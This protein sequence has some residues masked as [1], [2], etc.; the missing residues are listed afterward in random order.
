MAVDA[1][2]PVETKTVS[3][4]YTEWGEYHY[5]A[6]F[7]VSFGYR[8]KATTDASLQLKRIWFDGELIYDADKGNPKVGVKLYFKPGTS[9]QMPF[10]NQDI[11]YRDQ[12]LL[13]FSNVDLGT[14]G[15]IPAVTAEFWDG[16]T[17][18]VAEAIT[19]LSERAG[20]DAS[21]VL[22]ADYL[23]EIELLGYILD[24]QASL[25]TT[26]SDLAFLYNFTY[27]EARGQINVNFAY[28]TVG[29]F[30]PDV[31]IADGEL[32]VLSEA[33][34][35]PQIDVIAVA[36]D[37]A[38]PRSITGS[39]FDFDKSYERG[40]ETAFRRKDA[41]GSENDMSFSMPVVMTGR[42][43][44]SRLFDALARE[45]NER[46]AHSLRLPTANVAVEPGTTLQW[47]SYGN[48]YSG[49][50]VTAV[51]NADWSNTLSVVEILAE[52]EGNDVDTTSPPL[53]DEYVSPNPVRTVLMDVPDWD[54]NQTKAGLLN[55]RVAMARGSD[56]DTWLGGQFDWTPANSN[57]WTTPAI[58]G[59]DGEVGIGD[60]ISDDGPTMTFYYNSIDP[61]RFDD[62]DKLL[63]VGRPGNWEL[64]TFTDAAIASDGRVMISGLSR[65]LYGTD[66]F[67]NRHRGELIDGLPND[68]VIDTVVFANDT[69]TITYTVDQ[70]RSFTDF[71]WRATPALGVPNDETQNLWR[72]SGNSRRPY[73]PNNVRMKRIFEGDILIE[74]DR[75]DGRFGG[76]PDT[77]YSIDFFTEDWS[78]L[79]RRAQPVWQEAYWYYAEWQLEDGLQLDSTINVL[80]YQMNAS[81][82][83]R[84]F[85]GGGTIGV[86][87]SDLTGTIGPVVGGSA[88][89]RDLRPWGTIPIVARVKG[90]TG[91]LR[92]GLAEMPWNVVIGPVVGLTGVFRNTWAFGTIGPVAGPSG[93]LTEV[94]WPYIR[95][96]VACWTQGAN[97]G[98]PP[99]L[100]TGSGLDT[101]YDP[102]QSYVYVGDLIIIHE[103]KRAGTSSSVGT[104]GAPWIELSELDN[105]STNN[106][107]QRIWYAYMDSD[108]T[109]DDVLTNGG[110]PCG[111]YSTVNPISENMTQVVVVHN[112]DPTTPIEDFTV[113]K[114]TSATSLH[115]AL[116]VDPDT[117]ND[118]LLALTASRTASGYLPTSYSAPSG[119]DILPPGGVNSWNDD[120]P[121]YANLSLEVAAAFEYLEVD[122]PTGD[123][124]F[125]FGASAHYMTAMMAIKYAEA[126]SGPTIGPHAY[127]RMYVTA[128]NGDGNFV[129]ANGIVFY[130]E[131]NTAIPFTGASYFADS[132]DGLDPAVRA[133]GPYVSGSYYWQ[134]NSAGTYPRYVG[135][136]FASPVDARS[137]TLSYIRDP[138]RM[139]KTFRMEYSDDGVTWTPCSEG[140]YPNQTGWVSTLPPTDIRTFAC[141][142]I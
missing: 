58:F 36:S 24:G 30:T 123:K 25:E 6:S 71:S 17:L 78:R 125:T 22:V 67:Q 68:D 88:F 57:T 93:E 128:N 62:T 4:T 38:L 129:C 32:A 77:R 51:L 121:N 118:L 130:D 19:T 12:I 44:R 5:F 131:T 27:F 96:R 79:I 92:A 107:Y 141:T 82:V 21:D 16:D 11:G 106:L 48:T 138:N 3:V 28:D 34:E 29:S 46:N 53:P 99:N 56:T 81:H 103:F 54:E 39:F 41:S 9:D 102:L 40:S 104:R 26:L 14:N 75:D 49:K 135:V 120:E 124:T 95:R 109:I 112:V 98:S 55:L 85:P 119:M 15:S 137:F 108:D 84:G 31:V 101:D 59:P 76:E 13:Y 65:G 133:F 70:Y 115:K 140:F 126:P 47:A 122:T 61:A 94:V 1:D 113:N 7:C 63:I 8:G 20:F 89:M 110:I 117:V 69:I 33:S 73:S 45:W 35:N 10:E 43:M 142:A 111:P 105:R 74:W 116:S 97:V 139:P 50:V 72:P 37:Q 90:L 18:T 87:E 134:S 100:W 66:D 132:D 80:V 127:W 136:H 2:E 83:G 52:Y 42:E 86:I 64:L 23:S 91:T 114:S 60:L